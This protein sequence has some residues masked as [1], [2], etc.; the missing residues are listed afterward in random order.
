[1]SRT[2]LAVSQREPEK[3]PEKDEFDQPVAVTIGV[4]DELNKEVRSEA[5]L[6]RWAG[7]I[8]GI[9]GT[10]IVTVVLL[11]STF[12]ID[13]IAAKVKPETERV[14]FLLLIVHG[15]I[16]IAAVYFGYSMLRVSERMFVPRRLLNDAKDVEVIRAIL[17][18]STPARAV[19]A[20]LR[21][22]SGEVQALAKTATEVIKAAHGDS[23]KDG[24]SE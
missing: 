1:M 2:K 8:A 10:V 9:L 20:Q 5:S 19:A 22:A 14:V 6:R 16:S 18:V 13:D 15:V 17:G 23:A 12:A 21:A 24:K 3:E 4:A 11:Y 7:T